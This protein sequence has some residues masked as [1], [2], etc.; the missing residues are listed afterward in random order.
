[1]APGSSRTSA[2]AQGES[3]SN[4]PAEVLCAWIWANWKVRGIEVVLTQY[5][6]NNYFFFL[7]KGEA[8]ALN[9][10]AAWQWM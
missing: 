5:I 8:M 2:N 3:S 9:A 4:R 10:L 7:F 6:P 1:M